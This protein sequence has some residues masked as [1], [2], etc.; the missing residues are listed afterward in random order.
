MGG[1]RR[2]RLP[3]GNGVRI[4]HRSKDPSAEPA[5]ASSAYAACLVSV[6]SGAGL[7]LERDAA[8]ATICR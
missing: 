3:A 4:G 8:T 1:V 2:Q 7:S 5:E 6:L